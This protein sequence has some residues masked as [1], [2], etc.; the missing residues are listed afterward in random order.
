MHFYTN[1]AVYEIHLNAIAYQKNLC[2]CVCVSKPAAKTMKE[3][4]W[5]DF[6][7]KLHVFAKTVVLTIN[8]KVSESLQN[9]KTARETNAS[10]CNMKSRRRNPPAFARRRWVPGLWSSASGTK[11]FLV[12]RQKVALETKMNQSQM[13]EMFSGRLERKI[14]SR[15]EITE[16]RGRWEKRR[17]REAVAHRSRRS[18]SE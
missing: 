18:G 4:T 16:R 2:T 8:W 14:A 1:N 15:E 11:S 7:W 3:I 13:R 17:L 10:R 6:Q 5:A 12:A 9:P